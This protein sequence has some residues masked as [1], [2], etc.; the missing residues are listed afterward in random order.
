MAKRLVPVAPS[1]SSTPFSASR[2]E[3]GLRTVMRVSSICTGYRVRAREIQLRPKDKPTGGT[4]VRDARFATPAWSEMRLAGLSD[5]PGH[6]GR[7]PCRPELL[8]V[9]Q[10]IFSRSEERRVGQARVM[11]CR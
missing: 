7:N 5:L 11:T 6:G 3:R 10:E 8:L 9:L 4:D 2:S 1:A